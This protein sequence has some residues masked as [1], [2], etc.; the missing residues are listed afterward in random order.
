VAAVRV[1]LCTYRRNGLL[2][3]AVGSLLAQTFT[4][5]VCELHNDDPADPFPAKLASEL[6]DPRIVPVTHPENYGP[7]RA[8]NQMYRSDLSERYA[9]LLEDDNWWDPDFLLRMVREMD[10]RPAVRVGWAN[11]R[12]WEERS[13][14]SWRDTGRCIWDA[15]GGPQLF[16]WPNRRQVFGAAVSNG[17]MV[18]RA[19]HLAE[20]RIPDSTPF[21][22]AE[23]VRER[24][25]R[26]PLLLC[27]EPLANF[28][29]TRA[30]ARGEGRA[31]W[32]QCQ[33]L[34]AASFFRHVR[35]DADAT[36]RVWAAARAAAPPVTSTLIAAG[37][38]EPAAR[39]LLRSARLTDWARFAA[40]FV[41]R[42]GMSVRV[43]RAKSALP[44]VWA[45]LD[46]GT[47]AT[48]ERAGFPTRFEDARPTEHERD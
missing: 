42:P 7:T 48:H 32:G 16:P 22:A 44:D 35:L 28:A 39:H 34:L 24:S 12:L 30:T 23:A 20:L 4:D 11:M 29:V 45:V 31:V 26:H 46:A 17:A 18:V 15:S 19:E 5:W 38:V 21:A 14:G 6:G 43:L 36:R 8:F 3:R 27:H 40:A 33:V 13:D 41:K 10:H 37:L 25:F 47:R 1:F 2:R 9:S